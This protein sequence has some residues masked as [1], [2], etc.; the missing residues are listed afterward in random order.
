MIIVCDDRKIVTST[1]GSMYPIPTKQAFIRV[2][3]DYFFRVDCFALSEK[4][5]EERREK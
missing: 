5:L 2:S 4:M 3:G 1:G